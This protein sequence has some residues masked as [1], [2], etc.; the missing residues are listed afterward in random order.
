MEAGQIYGFRAHGPFE[1][2]GA[3]GSIHLSH[4]SGQDR[5]QFEDVLIGVESELIPV[6]LWRFD[7]DQQQLLVVRSKGLR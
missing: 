3:S 4:P 7:N 5:L 6:S 1:Q 2:N